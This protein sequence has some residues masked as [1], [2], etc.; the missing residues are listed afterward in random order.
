MAEPPAVTCLDCAPGSRRS[1]V[2]GSRCATHA[3]A[4]A[5][6]VRAL[7]AQRR[8]QRVYGLTAEQDERIIEWQGGRCAICR[9]ATGA[10]KALAVDHN[11]A[12]GEV[13][14][15]LCSTCNQMIGRWGEDPLVFVR[16]A[17]Y[18]LAPPSRLALARRCVAG[19][20]NWAHQVP[21]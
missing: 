18:L 14:G 12:T 2:D 1:L 15:R 6:A 20:W 21:R 17:L 10:S 7:A 5:K 16:A 8:R 13:R 19:V 4:H 3:R 9:R 11:H